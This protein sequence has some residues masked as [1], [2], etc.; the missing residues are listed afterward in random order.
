[1]VPIIESSN[2]EPV[3][4]AD[5]GLARKRSVSDLY[6]IHPKLHLIM[7]SVS[8][9]YAVKPATQ[10]HS[11][12]VEIGASFNLK[13]KVVIGPQNQL[14]IMA[15]SGVAFVKNNAGC[16]VEVGNKYRNC[17]GLMALPAVL[18]G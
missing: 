12:I 10:R 8:D 16:G 15:G 7:F 18:R 11:G 4:V 13:L 17:S 1:M 2:L 14:Q 6:A 5:I 9:A 3:M